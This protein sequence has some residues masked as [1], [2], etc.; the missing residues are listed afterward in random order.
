MKKYYFYLS[1]LLMS[2]L[3]AGCGKT[4]EPELMALSE[5]KIAEIVNAWEKKTGV[6]T[7]WDGEEGYYGTYQGSVVFHSAGIEKGIHM[8]SHWVITV[9]G[10]N[11]EWTHSFNIYVYS[12]KK[13]YDL[14]TAYKNGLITEAN[15]ERIADYHYDYLSDRTN[16]KYTR[17]E[18]GN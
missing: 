1:L 18:K 10:V 8:S 16:G 13:I 12:D 5:E 17:P 9:G 4:R 3:L 2:I 11:Y 15:L 7:Q 6:E 14:E